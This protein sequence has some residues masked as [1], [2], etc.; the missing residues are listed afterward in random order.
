MSGTTNSSGS[1]NPPQTGPPRAVGRGGSLPPPARRRPSPGSRSASR[2]WPGRRRRLQHV[3]E[4]HHGLGAED[5]RQGLGQGVEAAGGEL[6]AGGL[7]RLLDQ[8]RAAVLAR[9]QAAAR[10]RPA[11]APAIAPASSAAG[12]R[13]PSSSRRWPCPR[14]SSRATG[15]V[16]RLVGEDALHARHGHVQLG[17]EQQLVEAREVAIG[18]GAR[19]QGGLG[20]LL[21]ARACGPASSA[22]RPPPADPCA[23]GASGWGGR[24]S[25]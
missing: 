25:R 21:Q 10:R 18:G 11:G 4:H 17:L 8:R 13:W 6:G 22:G 24:A 20:D 14:L 1:G 19:D 23:C 9:R 15:S 5:Q 12:S 16:A 3:L 7:Q 2:A